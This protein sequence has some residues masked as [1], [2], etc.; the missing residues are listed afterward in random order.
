M[1]IIANIDF[2]LQG[3]KRAFPAAI[4]NIRR[5]DMTGADFLLEIRA[6]YVA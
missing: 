6:V 1:G 5:L 4:T 3:A 2:F